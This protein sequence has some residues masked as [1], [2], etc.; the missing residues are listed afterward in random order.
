[1]RKKINFFFLLVGISLLAIFVIIHYATKSTSHAFQGMP[2]VTV[3][4][5][6]ACVQTW[7]EG[8]SAVGT[9]KAFHGV[10]ISSAVSGKVVN[11]YFKSGDE[12]Q[13]G[14]LLVELDCNDL[15]ADL[16]NHQA[17]LELAASNYQRYLSLSKKQFVSAADL[18]KMRAEWHQAQA[19]VQ[20]S[21]ALL[22]QHLIKAPFAGKL[23][24]NQVDLGQYVSAGQTL[25]TLETLTPIFID[26][27]LPERYSGHVHVGDMV[28]LHVNAES[29]GHKPIPGKIVAISPEVDSI[30][31]N[32]TLRVQT[33]NV[34]QILL[35]G[36][37][38][39]VSLNLDNAQT[40]VVIPQ[41]AIKYGPEGAAVFVVK[42]KTVHLQPI[43]VG[44]LK[45][46]LASV[47]GGLKPGDKVV[48]AGQNK[49]H[50]GSAVT[51][52]VQDEHA[53]KIN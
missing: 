20:Q 23:G 33:D 43:K 27:N 9:V 39:D 10:G 18:D 41:T 2:P 36:M 38:A 37:F 8:V 30:S 52:D 28:Q 5:S 48:T 45:D 49:L 42:N 31:R 46:D 29:E 21:E 12:V 32:L 15:R 50:E 17:R 22:A 26:F 13:A 6:E 51:S 7:A 3:S 11:S 44:Q 4:V 53:K 34:N 1:M 25:V 24:I 19:D 40:C 14:Q 35:P 47:S 16:A